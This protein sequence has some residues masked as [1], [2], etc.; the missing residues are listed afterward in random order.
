MLLFVAV[1]SVM[2]ISAQ[3]SLRLTTWSTQ[4]VRD[5]REHENEPRLMFCVDIKYHW[6]LNDGYRWSSW[7]VTK[8][9]FF[10]GDS[11]VGGDYVVLLC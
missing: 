11:S 9:L 3:K 1:M 7:V 8:M 2:D 4:R 6:P 10:S 5:V